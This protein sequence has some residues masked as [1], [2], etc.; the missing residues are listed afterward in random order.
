MKTD[1]QL[2][3]EVE[4][5]LEFNPAVNPARIGVEMTERIVASS[6]HPAMLTAR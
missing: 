5:E 2:K 6:G 3:D 1:Q 4:E